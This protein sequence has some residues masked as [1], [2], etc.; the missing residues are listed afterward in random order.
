MSEPHLAAE[1]DKIVE[2]RWLV[3]TDWEFVDELLALEVS[4][5][6]CVGWLS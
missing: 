6:P 5:G 4:S 2:W 1:Q 3:M